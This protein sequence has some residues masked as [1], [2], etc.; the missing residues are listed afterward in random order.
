MTAA[1]RPR[2]RAVQVF[3][4]YLE[5]GGEEKSVDRIRRQM[6]DRWDIRKCFFDSQE[7]KAEPKWKA[8]FQVARMFSNRA[9]AERLRTA[10]RE[11]QPDFL[12]FHNIYP[13]G[14]PVLYRVALEEKIPVVQFIHNFRPF[15]AGGALW[16]GDRIAW[17]ALKGDYSAEIKAGSWQGSRPRTAI[18]A[19]V[20]K[21]LHRSGWLDGVKG[22]IGISEF[23]RD[24]FIQAGVPANRAHALRH[25]WEPTNTE[26]P[27][28]PDGEHYLFLSRLVPEK[29]V[30]TLLA[31]WAIL[32]ERLGQACPVLVV[33]GTGSEEKAVEQ[34][35]A[36]SQGTIRF[37][38][39]V[40]G[41]QKTELLRNS[42]AMLA[43]SIWLEPLGLVTYEAYDF[44]KPM[45]AAAS[46]G[47]SETVLDGKTGFLHE[48]G[49][50]PS[51]A[52]TIENLELLS[53][54]QRQD[55]GAAGHQWLLENT[56]PGA[57]STTLGE[58]VDSV[59]K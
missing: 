57:W 16:A 24:T 34:A 40:D 20:L 21:R 36:K 8:P 41:D 39:F 9:A 45:L 59:V 44:G 7:W 42:R 43:P 35:A 37:V 23:M 3:N 14:S 26:A 47:L 15:S 22:W 51:L 28:F 18:M 6:A 30:A 10:I 33:G 38:G 19:A 13:V 2:L 50:A 52:A 31:A 27:G 4:V 12:L 17:E 1:D 25:C 46:G 49:D 11:H 32:Q 58:I 48:P 29:G 56:D 53:P 54:N 55:M 5:R